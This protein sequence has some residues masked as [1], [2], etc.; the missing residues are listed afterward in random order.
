M[1]TPAPGGSAV[2]NPANRPIATAVESVRGE[3]EIL[4][5]HLVEMIE[6]LRDF[7]GLE[8]L[9]GRINEWEWEERLGKPHRRD[10]AKRNP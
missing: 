10:G 1:T 4:N 5:G 6:L 2:A 8:Q 9:R 7:L 3:L